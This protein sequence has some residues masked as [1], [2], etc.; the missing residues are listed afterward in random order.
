ME[1]GFP[2]ANVKN[3]F[4]VPSALSIAVAIRGSLRRGSENMVPNGVCFFVDDV[5]DVGIG[6]SVRWFEGAYTA[7]ILRTDRTK[8][9]LR[10]DD[11]DKW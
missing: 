7:Y 6:T 11:F 3:D 2:S 5:T 9:T 10:S 8:I 4:K 1:P